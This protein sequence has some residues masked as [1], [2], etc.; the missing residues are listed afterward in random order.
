MNNKTWLASGFIALV[1]IS[2][3]ELY[4]GPAETREVQ[5][6][7]KMRGFD[8]GPVDGISGGKT[9]AA[10]AAYEA[11][12]AGIASVCD[13]MNL[14]SREAKKQMPQLQQFHDLKSA[15]TCASK[16]KSF[17]NFAG[18][19]TQLGEAQPKSKK[20]PDYYRLAE[21][22]GN[23]GNLSLCQD[24]LN[25]A[26]KRD[27]NEGQKKDRCKKMLAGEEDLKAIDRDKQAKSEFAAAYTK[28]GDAQ[29]AEDWDRCIAAGKEMQAIVRRYVR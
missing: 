18:L 9:R 13:G 25:K 5:T 2:A 23:K 12:G 28:W 11:T 24:L 3:G 8:P 16:A 26:L 22:A 1:L 4:A 19:M 15:E 6:C 10:I 21:A 20:L 7:L 17:T 27:F 29:K 14:M